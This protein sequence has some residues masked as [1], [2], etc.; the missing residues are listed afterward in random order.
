M[1][2][3]KKIYK[4]L[5]LII[6]FVISTCIFFLGLNN[7]PTADD[8]CV[9]N[10][11]DTI[12]I[13]NNTIEF[14]KN[15]SG[16]IST[17]L[18]SSIVF[19]YNNIFSKNNYFSGILGIIFVITIIITTSLFFKKKD[20]IIKNSVY[21][22]GIF[23]LGLRSI[24]SETVF[25]VAGGIVYILPLLIAIFWAKHIQKIVF[26]KQL[27]KNNFLK[28]LITIIISFF[29]GNSIEPISVGAIVFVFLFIVM[30]ND[31]LNKQTKLELKLI[32]VSTLIGSIILFISKGNFIR[33]ESDKILTLNTNINI[34]IENY[35]IILFEYIK[36]GRTLYTLLILLLLFISKKN[37]NNKEIGIIYL[38]TSLSMI[39][40]ITFI[41]SQENYYS[42]PRTTLFFLF[43]SSISIVYLSKPHI[44]SIKLY[45]K[46]KNL[47]YFLFAIIIIV[48]IMSDIILSKNIKNQMNARNYDITN[49]KHDSIYIADPIKGITPT[50]LKFNDITT[51][52]SSWINKCVADYYKI[53]KIKIK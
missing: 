24:I 11:V 46:Y 51:D 38:I 21:F 30:Y 4:K 52:E 3:I 8:F 5:F 7:W 41:F 34:L 6:L 18:I 32:F 31:K 47:L 40:P 33:L 15:H 20:E 13:K 37:T 14:Y 36:R 45:R 48:S 19:K 26:E 23:W 49:K 1:L 12:G 22:L 10:V 39:I 29:V 35:F 25:W 9:K 2:D 50:S 42:E 44:T 28:L 43:F 27:K 53:P 17:T 16:R